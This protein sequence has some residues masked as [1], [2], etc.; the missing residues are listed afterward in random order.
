M[1]TR[2]KRLCVLTIAVLALS[3]LA[4]LPAASALQV[5]AASGATVQTASVAS[6]PAVADYTV[7][8]SCI[9]RFS[10]TH[11]FNKHVHL[12]NNCSGTYYVKVIIAYG[13]DS[14]CKYLPR[15]AT[16]THSWSYGWPY[17]ASRLDRV[18]LC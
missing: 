1:P 9:Y 11:L 7:A 8:P 2:I 5:D 15:G 3:L 18:E 16:A 4:G 10:H 17:A 14:G 12:Q 13:P 6:S